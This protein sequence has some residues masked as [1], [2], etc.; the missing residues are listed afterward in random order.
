MSGLHKKARFIHLTASF[1]EQMNAEESR[2]FYCFMNPAE[3]NQAPCHVTDLSATSKIPRNPG[4]INFCRAGHAVRP[5]FFFTAKRHSYHLVF[6]Y[7][8]K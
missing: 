3:K 5:I 1:T 8:S 6:L 4:T 7:N 2:L